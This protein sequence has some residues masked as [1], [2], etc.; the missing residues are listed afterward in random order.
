M[1][2]ISIVFIFFSINSQLEKQNPTADPAYSPLLNGVWE[3][4]SASLLTPGVLGLQV[5]K[6]LPGSF[7]TVGD[8][9][10][11]IQSISPRVKAQT[12]VQVG[13]M[14]MEVAVVTDLQAKTALRLSEAYETA[15]IGDFNLPLTSLRTFSRDI[16]VSYLDEDL[17]IA[18]DSFGTPEILRRKVSN[19]YFKNNNDNNDKQ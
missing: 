9:T 5:I 13:H 2:L 8:I 11:T 14:N 19:N 12:T 4:V 7:I 15:A 18:R 1:L 17:M 3:V 16:I 10:I 6:Q